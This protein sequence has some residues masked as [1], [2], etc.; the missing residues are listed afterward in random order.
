SL[1]A[2]HCGHIDRAGA[3]TLRFA[4]RRECV[5]LRGVL[6]LGTAINGSLSSL[7]VALLD[8][9]L[10]KGGPPWIRRARRRCGLRLGL[11]RVGQARRGAVRGEWQLEH[12]GV[13]CE[14]L[15]I[16]LVTLDRIGLP[17][18]RFGLEELVDVELDRLVELREA[19]AAL[20]LP[21]GLHGAT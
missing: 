10:G 19:V 16:D 11:G 20:A 4:E 8:V 5:R 17:L 12:H 1:A 21:P 9:E 13:A 6:R 7:R 14:L 3:A 15:E 18:H 2:P